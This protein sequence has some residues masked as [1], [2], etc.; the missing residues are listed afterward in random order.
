MP[1]ELIIIVLI[2]IVALLIYL[3]YLLAVWVWTFLAEV[4]SVILI[5]VLCV[6]FIG[7]FRRW[8][9]FQKDRQTSIEAERQ[10][11]RQL[12]ANATESARYLMQYLSPRQRLVIDSSIWMDD[13]SSDFFQGLVALLQATGTVLV[14]P[15][16]QYEEIEAI[17][18][19]TKFGEPK[20]A[21][22]RMAQIRIERFQ[23]AG[24]LQIPKIA[25]IFRP[26][27]YVDPLLIQMA[28][29][30]ANDGGY[31]TLVTHDRDMRIRCREHLRGR[32]HETTVYICEGKD[33]NHA[34][35]W[36][37]QALTRGL[38][39]PRFD[40]LDSV[41]TVR[42]LPAHWEC[43]LAAI[44]LSGFAEGLK[45]FVPWLRT[46]GASKEMPVWMRIL[47]MIVTAAVVAAVIHIV[48]VPWLKWAFTGNVTQV[49]REQRAVPHEVTRG[50]IFKETVIEYSW[51]SFDVSHT[52]TVLHMSWVWTIESIM[53]V[54]VVGF[55]GARSKRYGAATELAGSTRL[56]RT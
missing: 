47:R 7:G 28:V 52:S 43:C 33:V 17:K 37:Q 34:V 46:T 54:V 19:R 50:I 3:I 14:M 13:G 45:R 36:V 49:T 55:I 24:C 20:N 4:L 44:G 53:T 9:R 27:E 18:G 8:R 12:A 10:E 31:L 39:W 32:P 41:L 29:Q 48:C 51:E 35:I 6:A 11:I 42:A 21:L 15:A 56:T 1:E 25:I 26:G 5:I 23:A 38:S 2:A 30:A 22:A 40:N 16:A